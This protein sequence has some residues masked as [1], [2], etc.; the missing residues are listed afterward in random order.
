MS[1]FFLQVQL[2]LLVFPLPLRGGNGNPFQY[3]CLENSMDRGAWLTTV[4]GVAKSQTRLSD[5]CSHLLTSSPGNAQIYPIIINSF[6]I[7][8]WRLSSSSLL[9]SCSNLYCLFSRP[10]AE[11]SSQYF[12]LLPF[13][14]KS[15]F[16]N[17]IS[18][19]FL[20]FVLVKHI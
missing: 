15:C 7:I 14:V 4:H 11:L 13:W 10:A 8:F 3:S 18:S 9:F 20:I 12:P 2:T 16:L 6:L 17:S 1:L 19:S 5:C